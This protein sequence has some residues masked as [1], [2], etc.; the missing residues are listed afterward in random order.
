MKSSY[1]N[2]KTSA[3]GGIA[4]KGTQ[5]GRRKKVRKGSHVGWGGGHK[6]LG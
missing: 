5:K 2:L 1:V 6:L 4:K 3:D